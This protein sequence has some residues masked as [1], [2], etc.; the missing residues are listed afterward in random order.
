MVEIIKNFDWDITNR[1]VMILIPHYNRPKYVEA[2]V[3]A[4]ATDMPIDD[5][6]IIIGND[7]IH[8]DFDHL[9]RY[10]AYSYTILR[11]EGPVALSGFRNSGFNR[12][13]G[14]KNC[15]ADLFVQKDPEVFV[16]GEFLRKAWELRDKAASRAGH[17]MFVERSLSERV[18]VEGVQI[19]NEF[20]PATAFLPA[21]KGAQRVHPEILY[22]TAP[23]EIKYSPAEAHLR[24]VASKGAVHFSSYYAYI[25]AMG[26]VVAQAM[27]GYDEDFT[28]FG[29]EDPDMFCRLMAN[30][31][32]ILPDF[33]TVSIHLAH[34]S[35]QGE[36]K[37][38][39]RMGDI[40]KGKDPA[41]IVR[42]KFRPWGV[43]A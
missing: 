20:I 30:G 14:L 33:N 37:E 17:V 25:F 39:H 8:F 22:Y 40:F 15:Q 9:R 24:M 38:V 6:V 35:T 1:K 21:E 36:P 3:K 7:S 12:N 10:N 28:N 4:F 32:P 29:W 43:G 5:W 19:L 42:N 41:N 27:R 13:Y 26:T 16:K 23:P 2:S 34:D 31:Y 11:N 18:L